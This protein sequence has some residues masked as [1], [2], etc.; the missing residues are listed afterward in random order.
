[1]KEKITHWLSKYSMLNIISGPAYDY[2][3]DGLP[4]SIDTINR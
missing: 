4:D 3:Y 2:N 1:M